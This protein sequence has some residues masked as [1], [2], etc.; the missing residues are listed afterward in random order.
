MSRVRLIESRADASPEQ[1]ETFDHIAAS[2]G[3]RMLRPYAAML[4][5]PDIARATADLGSVIRFSSQLSDHDRELVILTTA[6]ERVCSFERDA[7]RPLAADAGVEPAT[8]TSVDEGTAVDD[9]RD[10][11]IVDFVRSLCRVGK[12]DDVTHQSLVDMVG[13]EQVVE[14]AA[15]VGFYSMLAVFMGAFELC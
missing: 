8:L 11:V 1:L 9:R 12:V 14:V 4:H 2:R 13:D 15:V 5:R 6:I 3:G 10:A 7:H